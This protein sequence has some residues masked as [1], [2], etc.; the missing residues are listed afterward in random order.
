MAI[1][2]M[3]GWHDVI[4]SRVLHGLEWPCGIAE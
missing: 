3:V 2:R 1:V 4:S